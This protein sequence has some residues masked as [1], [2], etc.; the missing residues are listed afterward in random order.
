MKL[1]DTEYKIEV[2]EECMS[3]WLEHF[4]IQSSKDDAI[5]KLQQ[6]RELNPQLTYRL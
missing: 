6:F 4:T 5:T 1:F 2:Y 3:V